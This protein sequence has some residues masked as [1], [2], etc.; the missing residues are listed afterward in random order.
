MQLVREPIHPFEGV[1][2]AQRGAGVAEE[3]TI[4]RRF[5]PGRKDAVERVITPIAAGIEIAG[6]GDVQCGEK[7]I[8][9]RARV[10]MKTSNNRQRTSRVA[11]RKAP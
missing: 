6:L 9:F 11:E 3:N 10:V 5:R 2:I 4:R 1:A 7:R 8:H